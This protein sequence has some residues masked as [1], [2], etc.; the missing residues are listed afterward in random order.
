LVG[1]RTAGLDVGGVDSSADMLAICRAH[2]E[3]AGVPITLHRAD[4][5]TLDLP[6]RYATFY[7]PAGSFMLIDD[8]GDARRALAAWIAHLEPGGQLVVSGGVPRAH[9]DA[10]WEL[11]IRR[12][13][14][15]AR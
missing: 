7:N 9:F 8:E 14:A 2:A 12:S 15:R 6:R 4:W 10:R 11:P 5:T 13:A 1:Y 3:A